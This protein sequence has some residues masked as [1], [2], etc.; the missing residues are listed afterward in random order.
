MLA[1]VDMA[2]PLS[3]QCMQVSSN[4]EG[5]LAH[6]RGASICWDGTSDVLDLHTNTSATVTLIV[7]YCRYAKAGTL[8][9]Y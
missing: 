7:T 9:D 4:S 6:V 3:R 2:S 5:V 8:T 1:L